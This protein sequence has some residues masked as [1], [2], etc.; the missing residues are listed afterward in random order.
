VKKALLRRAKRPTA[1]QAGL[2]P[3]RKIL[4]RI[5]GSSIVHRAREGWAWLKRSGTGGGRRFEGAWSGQ[6]ADYRIR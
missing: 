1:G 4:L 5:A 6:A 2:R 3:R